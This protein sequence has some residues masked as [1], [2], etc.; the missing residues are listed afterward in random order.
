[1]RPRDFRLL[2]SGE[3]F[4]THTR[5]VSRI[6]MLF[7]EFLRQ[8]DNASKKPRGPGGSLRLLCVRN[9]SCKCAPMM[10]CR[11]SSLLP[12]RTALRHCDLLSR[13]VRS[14]D[15]SVRPAHTPR[16]LQSPV[17]ADA[18]DFESSPAVQTSLQP[19]A[20]LDVTFRMKAMETARMKTS[21][22]DSMSAPRPTSK[23]GGS[24]TDAA[25]PCCPQETPPAPHRRAAPP[26][27]RTRADVDCL[28]AFQTST[29][30]GS[31]RINCRVANTTAIS[32]DSDSIRN[33]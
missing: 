33:A 30:M 5:L 31:R 13:P 7:I 29:S 18:A 11:S 27:I 9:P 4:E 20:R 23:H 12:G 14:T 25:P 10:Y 15:G 21:H 2:F 3:S 22:V 24:A 26:I 8:C 1:M 17:S 16:M 6:I 32:R 19:R 28:P